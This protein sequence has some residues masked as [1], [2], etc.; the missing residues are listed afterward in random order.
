M[1][2]NENKF[3]LELKL[4]EFIEVDD[5]ITSVPIYENSEICLNADDILATLKI[6]QQRLEI[7]IESKLKNNREGKNE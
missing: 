1:T 7:F 2:A 4:T 5:T 6:Y 3:G